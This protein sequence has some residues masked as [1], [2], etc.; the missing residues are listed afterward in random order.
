VPVESDS[1]PPAKRLCLE[2]DQPP[3]SS[4]P[5]SS[6]LSSSLLVNSAFADTG[7]AASP[8]NVFES[9]A[10]Y[11]D[12]VERLSCLETMVV[13]YDGHNYNEEDDDSS[14]ESSTDG[15]T[16]LDEVL[17]SNSDAMPL[18]SRQ[19]TLDSYVVRFS[20][21]HEGHG[22]QCAGSSNSSF[23]LGSA[24]HC[25]SDRLPSSTVTSHNITFPTAAAAT[26]QRYSLPGDTAYSCSRPNDTAEHN[27]TVPG[28]HRL[29][30]FVPESPSPNY[31]KITDNSCEAD[32]QN[33]EVCVP[34]YISQSDAT[35]A[36]TIRCS[37][38]NSSV[39]NIR[40]CPYSE[41]SAANS[42]SHS[43]GDCT[44]VEDR[45]HPDTGYPAEDNAND[46]SGDS[47]VY[48]T[49]GWI[50][51]DVPNAT[52]DDDDYTQENLVVSDNTSSVATQSQCL[53]TENTH[54]FSVK[55]AGA[56]IPEDPGLPADTVEGCSI[57]A[58][59]TQSSHATSDMD[60]SV[61]G[62]SM[63][64]IPE[65]IRAV[66]SSMSYGCSLREEPRHVWSVGKDDKDNHCVSENTETACST[67]LESSGNN[68]VTAVTGPV[69]NDSC[70]SDGVIKST[71][72]LEEGDSA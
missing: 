46:A 60:H 27:Y 38:H 41:C 26:A 23:Q 35:A 50:I 48:A 34:G 11:F 54:A 69:L 52:Y 22:S 47:P 43:I 12:T 16:S 68:V 19:K 63:S 32:N 44:T 66:R 59:G 3:T 30:C 14:S 15:A 58:D 6:L 65:D 51:T 9:Q 10:A 29:S 36:H 57:M 31:R 70:G 25:S 21:Q 62:Y 2:S 1:S 45:T 28:E 53:A 4:Q 49:E 64:E 33:C 55:D 7:L 71:K 40:D 39:S 42:H 61:R 20:R 13:A 72:P 18:D 8:T 5:T 24:A 67:C 17:D 37:P 56:N